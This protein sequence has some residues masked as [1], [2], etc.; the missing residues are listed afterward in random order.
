MS[1]SRMDPVPP[2]SP[3]Q[4]QSTVRGDGSLALGVTLAWL[5][6]IVGGVFVFGLTML[7][8]PRAGTAIFALD[9]LP[10]LVT[11]G[12]AIWMIVKGPKRTGIGIIIGIGSICAVALLLVAACFGIFF[13]GN[14]H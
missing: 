7:L 9:W 4:P 1:E 2:P 14:R 8:T 10:F 12:L 3:P 11:V 6:N 13:L 5:I